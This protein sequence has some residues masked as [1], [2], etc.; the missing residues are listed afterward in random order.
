M[1]AAPQPG[2]TS[3]V[4]F[5]NRDGY[6]LSARID[7]PVGRPPAAWAVFAHCF[8]CSK[9]LPAIRNIS[10]ALTGHGL[11]VLRFDFTGLGDSEGD[12]ADTNFSS[13]VSDLHDACAWLS[14]QHQAPT[15]L[16]GH[17]LGAFIAIDVANRLEAMG[18]DVEL[19]AMLDPFLPTRT[20][21]HA[22]KTL[23]GVIASALL[24]EPAVSRGRLW[25]RRLLLP[26]AGLVENTPERKTHA[27]REVGVRVGRLHRPRPY[28]GRTLLVLSSF[29][30][31]DERV[32]PLVLTGDLTVR[33]VNCDHDSVVRAPHVGRVVDLVAE[34]RVQR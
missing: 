28:G 13:N 32:W 4:T 23:P 7:V 15:M 34:A 30:R 24:E 14:E 11:G 8:T 31:D 25:R 20:V 19:V 29:N 6:S 22:R 16:I 3:S 17:S 27:L 2:K 12:F 5:T 26:V 9:N 10:R 1:G 21:R 33:R 18:H